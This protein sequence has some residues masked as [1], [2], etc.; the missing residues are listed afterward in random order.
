MI[1][2]GSTMST[3]NIPLKVSHL[4]FLRVISFNLV[5]NKENVRERVINVTQP[6]SVPCRE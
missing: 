4:Y 6:A 1:S 2:Q 5:K 3:L